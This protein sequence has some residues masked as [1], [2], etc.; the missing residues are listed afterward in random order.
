MRKVKMTNKI[1]F[2]RLKN[3]FT[4]TE[5]GKMLGLTDD[6]I[7]NYETGRRTP[8]VYTALKLA[9]VLGTTVEEL[10]PLEDNAEDK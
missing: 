6:A 8:N 9:R 7:S 2:Y 5:V 3:G 10:F 1:R 4:Q